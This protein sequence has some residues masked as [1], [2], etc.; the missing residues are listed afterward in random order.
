MIKNTKLEDL[1]FCIPVRIDSQFRYR[2]LMAILRFY[3]KLTCAKFIILE[4]DSYQHLTK[5]PLMKNLTYRFI[6]DNN[7]IFHRTHYINKMLSEVET[8]IAAVWDTDVVAPVKQIVLAYKKI[9]YGQYVMVYPYDGRFWDINNFLSEIFYQKLCIKCLT[10]PLFIRYPLGRYSSVGGAFLVDVKKYKSCGW[11]NEYF[12]GWGPEDAE[13]FHRLEILGFTPGRISGALYHLYHS[14][15][16]NSG[17]GDE[18]LMISTRREYIRIC[19]METENLREYIQTWNW[20]S[21]I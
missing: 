14:R 21:N 6:L 18:N 12:I 10:N 17:R 8:E 4:A 11:E 19:S 2:N 16:I 15:G 5:L 20:I 13:R 1:T 3:S 7:P 9:R